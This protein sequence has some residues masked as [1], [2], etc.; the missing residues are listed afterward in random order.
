LRV[1]V[2]EDDPATRQRLSAAVAQSPRLQVV[3]T[4]GGGREALQWLEH[5]TPDV[6]LADLGLPDLPGL[7]VITYCAQRHPRCEIMVITMYEDEGH[8][9]RSLE[10]GA[11]G[12]LLKDT[13]PEE[14]VVRIHELMDGGAPMTPTIARQVLG[15]FHSR[16]ATAVGV[17]EGSAVALSPKELVVLTCIAQGFSYSEIAELEQISRHTVATHIRNAYAKLSVHSKNEAVF[18]ATRLGLLDSRW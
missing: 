8:V 13:T 1:V 15:R 10:A 16:P 17:L 3:A 6:L 18:E 2:V 7:A 5:H 14:V 9:M 4:F 11:G 12:Y